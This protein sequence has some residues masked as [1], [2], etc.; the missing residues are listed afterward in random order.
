MIKYNKRFD[1]ESQ[2][3][4]LLIDD[5]YLIKD[6]YV[7][8]LI[9][10]VSD[11]TISNI[12]DKGYD[13]F[14]GQHE[15]LLLN[16]LSDLDYTHCVVFTTG[17]EFINGEAFFETIENYIGN[18][19]LIAGHILDRKEAYYELH[20]QCYIINLS[21]YKKYNK[22]IIG[23]EQLGTKHRKI[24]PWRSKDNIHDD[25]TPTWV[26]G[27]ED[28]TD[29]NHKMHGHHILSTAFENDIPVLVF[30]NTIRQNKKY[31]YYDSLEELTW[32]YFRQS[33][34]QTTFVHHNSNEFPPKDFANKVTEVFT[35]ASGD[36][37]FDN[38][39]IENKCN[40]VFY[41]YNQK[42]LDY[43]KQNCKTH[44]NVTYDFVLID[45]LSMDLDLTHYLKSKN[46]LINLSNIFCYEGTVAFANLKFRLHREN[47]LISHV[48][49]K[50]PESYLYF[51]N[52]ACSGFKDVQYFGVAKNF[53]TIEL[54]SL[55]TPTY[56]QNGDWCV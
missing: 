6:N 22:P 8:E 55:K 39:D 38:L 29:Y 19:F 17:T 16:Q 1:R 5:T 26:N 40:V 24:K 18:D 54:D 21:L 11:Y 27:G 2:V 3:C 56:H 12:T 50:F 36:W 34:A 33:Y 13:L 20:K 4:F 47:K 7:K 31:H 30:D 52:R 48:I 41:D 44:P 51:C 45:L 28:E 42:S 10:N 9:K 49:D 43:W 15:D 53:T 25:Y 23:Q 14:H 37:W 46:P 35:P 32:L